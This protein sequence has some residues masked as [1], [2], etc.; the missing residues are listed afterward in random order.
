V[1]PADVPVHFL[2]CVPTS[3]AIAVAVV[4][5]VRLE[6]WFQHEIAGG[7]LSADLPKPVQAVHR[8][9]SG[10]AAAHSLPGRPLRRSGTAF[11][12]FRHSFTKPT[13]WTFSTIARISGSF[14]A[15]PAA[16]A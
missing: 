4:L 14:R 9:A 11:S 6:D 12:S 16:A 5:E 10:I 1:A 2:N 8:H 3:G 13:T 7:Y 15:N